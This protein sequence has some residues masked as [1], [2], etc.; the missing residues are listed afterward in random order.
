MK[1]NHH[2]RVR[3]KLR[4]FECGFD[5]DHKIR[6]S[7]SLRFFVIT[8]VFLVFDVEIALL[9]PNPIGYSSLLYTLNLYSNIVIF[10]IL[11]GGLIFE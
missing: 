2:N 3:E 5:P 11:A 6:I 8:V 9:F 4:P 1:R 10:I 7:F